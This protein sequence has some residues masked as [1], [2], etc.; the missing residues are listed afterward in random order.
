MKKSRQ[1]QNRRGIIIGGAFGMDNLGDEAILEAMLSELRGITDEPITVVTTAPEKTAGRFG[2][3]VVAKFGIGGF[4]RA[5]KHARLFISG[6]GS[7]IQDATSSRSLWYYL[8]LIA[9]AKLC[10]ARVLMGGCGIG[11][12]TGRLNR[13]LTRVVVNRCVEKI[14]LR[15]RISISELDNLRVSRPEVLL[16]A[17]FVFSENADFLGA[18]ES[19]TRDFALFILRSWGGI[20]EK[21]E[22]LADCAA[23]MHRKYGLTPCFL[24]LNPKDFEI[25]A[26]VSAVLDEKYP[27][28]PYTNMQT[29]KTPGEVFDAIK[30]ARV[31]LSVRLHGLIM[32]AAAGIP[33]VG[34]S[35]DP[36]VAGFMDY[37]ELPTWLP[38][39]EMSETRLEEI[40]DRALSD[41]FGERLREARNRLQNA[42][43]VNSEAIKAL[44]LE[45]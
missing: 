17:D 44:I 26:E 38:L 2:V 34:I 28:V 3:E 37:A 25:A 24:P 36:K 19:E 43:K 30:N 23:Y 4:I 41:E 45:A 33:V 8:F 27:G 13:Y 32:A 18:G 35:Y 14:T 15:D 11:P 31:C 29:V 10:G 39:G 6:G 5:A 22:T 21:V 42:E 16:A 1:K 20:K 40:I 7:L 12:V 9:A